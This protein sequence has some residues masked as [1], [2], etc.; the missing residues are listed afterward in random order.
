MEIIIL[1]GLPGSGKSTLTNRLIKEYDNKNLKVFSLRKFADYYISNNPNSLLSLEIKQQRALFNRIDGTCANKLFE[2]F[3]SNIDVKDSIILLENYPLSKKQTL[4]LQNKLSGIMAKI[5]VIFLFADHEILVHRMINRRIC[6]KCDKVG[7]VEKSYIYTDKICPICGTPLSSRSDITEL[8]N[9]ICTYSQKLN[10]VLKLIRF[11][12]Y[13]IDT[14]NLTE[15]EI[16][17]K[18]LKILNEEA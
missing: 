9:R 5:K 3:F 17:Y 11:E 7:W 2:L 10:E 8:Q 4:F 14:S 6:P 15:N 18:T 1:L 13:N 16:L 12:Q